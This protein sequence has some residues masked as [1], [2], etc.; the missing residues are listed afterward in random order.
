MDNNKLLQIF[1]TQE[2]VGLF[3]EMD[4]S[5]QNKILRKSFKKA[6]KIIIDEAKGNLGGRYTNV[7][8]SLTASYKA[9]IQTMNVGASKKK[10]G[11]MAHWADSG[12]KE[13]SYET[14]NGILHQTGRVTGT[15]FW[16]NAIRSSEGNVVETIY[17]D[18]KNEFDK[19]LQK[20]KQN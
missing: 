5:L 11:Y 3:N 10:G 16:T 8:K 20:K 2:L 9:D 19:I 6:A 15:G 4:G 1:G 13:R 7:S 14:K 18:I 17:K 12:T